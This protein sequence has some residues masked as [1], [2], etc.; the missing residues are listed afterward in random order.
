MQASFFKK[1][2]SDK[3][4]LVQG[5]FEAKNPGDILRVLMFPYP[6]Y[7]FFRYHKNP[8]YATFIISKK[9]GGERTILAPNS[10]LKEVQR[11]LNALLQVA[12]TH[13]NC[14]HGFLKGK[15]ILTN[16]R[17]HLRKRHVINF[18]ILNFFPTIHFGR[19]RGVFKAAPFHFNDD[20]A[21]FLANLCTYNSVLPQ[22]AP[23][24]PIISNLICRSLDNDLLSLSIRNKCAYTRY[25]DDITISTSLKDIPDQIGT[26]VDN[27]IELSPAITEIFKS[28]GFQINDKKTRLS[29]RYQSQIV[30]GLKVNKKLN[31]DRS[32]VRQIR[33]M[34]NNWKKFAIERVQ[35]DLYYKY[36]SNKDFIK[37]LQGRIGFLGSVKGLDNVT[38][39][40]LV[41]R[42]KSIDSTFKVGN[43]LKR[44]HKDQIMICTEG[45][46][47]WKHLKNALQRFKAAGEFVNLNLEFKE[48]GNL[49]VV[50]ADELMKMCDAASKLGGNKG[51]MLFLFDNDIPEITK[52]ARTTNSEFK[53]WNNNVY[54]CVL[55]TPNLPRDKNNICIEHFYPD[56]DI[57]TADENGRRLYLSG[58]F[59]K[60]SMRHLTDTDLSCVMGNKN[61]TLDYGIIDNDVFNNLGENVALS[62]ENFAN[63]VLNA[64]G[65]FGR[66]NI[67]Q[68][69]L[70]FN[71]VVEIERRHDQVMEIRL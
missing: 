12:T 34:L 44:A 37:V 49:D 16:A 33:A 57:K 28:N 10:G 61:S 51:V 68:F 3:E 71:I 45:K 22:G 30:T 36:N 65:D 39:L 46:T 64:S 48:W 4:A 20:T 23:T 59:N 52:K 6:A 13:K 47:D 55:P 8:S 18:D 35:S 9:S 50:N 62:K 5:F 66:V 24:S 53:I 70:V 41:K 56:T 21:T 2:E 25:A 60:K 58:E 15:S 67:D 1:L 7:W 29:N 32:Y 26:I 17:K 54:S 42:A 40:N 11:R 14:S 38:Y 43:E 19:V 31:V 27:K 69:R 63:N